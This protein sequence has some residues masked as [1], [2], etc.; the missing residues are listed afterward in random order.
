[1]TPRRGFEIGVLASASLLS[2]GVVIALAIGASAYDGH[3]ISFE[4]PKEPCTLLQYLVP[5]MLLLA[6]YSIAGRPIWSI[7]ALLVLLAL[8]AVGYLVGRRIGRP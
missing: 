2:L 1:M 5:Y 4:P 6:V 8:P 3:C 7:L